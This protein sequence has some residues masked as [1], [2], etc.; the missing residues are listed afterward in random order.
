MLWLSTWEDMSR[1]QWN[2]HLSKQ[3]VVL[4]FSK[5]AEVSEKLGEA[6]AA[7]AQIQHQQCA[8]GE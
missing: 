6:L 5:P 8:Q 1:P 7:V 4:L 2:S 3:T